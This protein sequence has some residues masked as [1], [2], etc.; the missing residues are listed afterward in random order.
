MIT[1][2]HQSLFD[3]GPA[4]LH[5]AGLTLRH[6]EQASP[7]ADGTTL[8]AQGRS[9]RPLTQTGTLLG[10]CPQQLTELVDQIEDCMDGRAYTLVDDT[11]RA[12][13]GV[14]M[15][16]FEPGPIVNLGPRL[17]VDYTIDYLQVNP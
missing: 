17:R 7:M 12:W 4:H 13:D 6:A 3:S 11:G 14:V 2:N 5:V 1:F 8:V 15:L 16:G 10:D 9:A